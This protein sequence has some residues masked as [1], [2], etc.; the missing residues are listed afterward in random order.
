[1][2]ANDRQRS[3][4]FLT[5]RSFVPARQVSGQSTRQL[6]PRVPFNERPPRGIF[7]RGID[8]LNLQSF[9]V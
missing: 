1:M 5:L 9:S 4:D 8:R 6:E 7:L 2:K 3:W